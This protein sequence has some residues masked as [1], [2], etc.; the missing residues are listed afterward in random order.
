MT[1]TTIDKK[2]SNIR[3]VGEQ[4]LRDEA[5]AVL[6]LIPQMDDNFNKAVEMMYHCNCHLIVTGLGTSGNRGA[7]ISATLASPGTPS[8]FLNPQPWYPGTL[9]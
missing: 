1:T 4:C 7:P 3:H 8:L 6:E 9:G 5:Q 2:M